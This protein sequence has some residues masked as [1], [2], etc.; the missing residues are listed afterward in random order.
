MNTRPQYYPAILLVLLFISSCSQDINSSFENEDIKNLNKETSIETESFENLSSS[1]ISGEW[2]RVGSS[3]HGKDISVTDIP[4]I[5]GTNNKIYSFNESTDDWVEETGS[6]YGKMI[7]QDANN[8]YIRGNNN[9]IYTKSK[10]SGSWSLLIDEEVNSIS[11]SSESFNPTYLQTASYGSN[12]S[13]GG[14]IPL[15]FND[16]GNLVSQFPGDYTPLKS[17]NVSSFY[18]YEI[19][20]DSNSEY[21]ASVFIQEDFPCCTKIGDGIY[22]LTTNSNTWEEVGGKAKDIAIGGPNNDVWI[23]GDDYNIYK[24]VNDQWVQTSTGSG[25]RISVSDNGVP[26]IIGENNKIYKLESN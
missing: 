13:G 24:L 8:L 2:V 7:T 11:A 20:R 9:K 19:V 10:G 15:E 21:Y 3:G 25:K 26:Y 5:I 12:W 4:Y 18:V 6:G 23:I 17:N 14:Y 1:T 16:S 22:K